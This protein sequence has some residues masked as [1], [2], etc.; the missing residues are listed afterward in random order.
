MAY[1]TIL[2]MLTMILFPVLVPAIITLFHA[3]TPEPRARAERLAL[4]EAA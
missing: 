3:L 1:L 4:A 2:G